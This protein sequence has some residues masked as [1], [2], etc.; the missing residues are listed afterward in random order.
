MLL[1][2]K[3]T[4][5]PHVDSICRKAGLKLNAISRIIPYMAFSKRRLLVNAFFSSQFN[6]CLLIWMFHNRML[7]N[8]INR[9]HVRCLRIIYNDK[10][11]SFEKLLEKDKSVSIHQKN[12][13]VLATEMFK[14][15]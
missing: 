1:D 6:Y 13:Q 8:R 9:L 14:I 5:K 11:T 12:L 15:Y 2:S 10:H 7:N 4:F 3:L